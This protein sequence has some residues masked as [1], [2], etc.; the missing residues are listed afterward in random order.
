MVQT[1]NP[2][3]VLI[4]YMGTGKTTI[5][6]RCARALRFRFVDTDQLVE[7]ATA[8]PVPQIFASEGEA[9][10]RRLEREAV[11]EAAMRVHVVIGTGGGAV[12]DPAN[13]VILRKSGVLVWLRVEP[14]E[15]LRR[16]GDRS[17]RPLLAGVEDPLG[18]IREMLDLRNPLYAAAADATVDTTGLRHEDAA[19]KVLAAYRELASRW[20]GLRRDREA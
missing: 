16:C 1:L 12:L 6:R 3:L 10:F 5:G 19:A 14:E 20:V 7:R 9:A 13:V 11:A 2:N 17:S 8:R 18:R 4:G 15:I